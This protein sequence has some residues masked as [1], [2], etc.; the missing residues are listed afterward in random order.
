MAIRF[1]TS[2]DFRTSKDKI[3]RHLNSV[4][5]KETGEKYHGRLHI[6]EDIVCSSMAE[7]EQALVDLTVYEFEDHAILYKNDIGRLN[8]LVYASFKT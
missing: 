4:V 6:H 2:Y 3:I 8:W 5:G 7:A 1:Y